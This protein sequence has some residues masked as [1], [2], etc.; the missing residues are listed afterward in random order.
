MFSLKLKIFF[1]IVLKVLSLIAFYSIPF[2]I[3]KGLDNTLSFSNFMYV[4]IMTCFSLTLVAWIPT[5]GA[6]GASEYAFQALFQ[7]IVMSPNLVITLM[8]T[9]KLFTF[10]FMIL[11]G[12]INSLI[13]YIK[14]KK[15]KAVDSSNNKINNETALEVIDENR[16][17]H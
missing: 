9:W 10:Y 2:F 14:S 4:V 12:G 8:I 13:L 15:I 6:A 11:V 16:D 5:P 17:I 7:G 1:T 3:L